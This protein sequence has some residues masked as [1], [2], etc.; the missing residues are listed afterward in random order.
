M[1]KLK[2][3]RQKKV[4]SLSRDRR[5]VYGENDKATRKNLPRKKARINRAFRHEVH[6]GLRVDGAP[7]EKLAL[8]ELDQ[9]VGAVRRKKFKKQPDLPLVEFI[10]R[11]REK[12][13][14][15][16]LR[17]RAAKKPR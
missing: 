14:M 7:V 6:Q 16:P 2:S 17:V 10:D 12:R 9:E 3:P 15:P 8:E 11:Q 5:N 1:S 13:A 4:A